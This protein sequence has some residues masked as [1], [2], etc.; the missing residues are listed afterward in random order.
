MYVNV[1]TL[2]HIRLPRPVSPD[3]HEVRNDNVPALQLSKGLLHLLDGTVHL[4]LHHHAIAS[5]RGR[6]AL[7]VLHRLVDVGSWESNTQSNIDTQN[8][9]VLY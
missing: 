2:L 1:T 7:Q 5:E 6:A 3:W 4:L 9:S 8:R